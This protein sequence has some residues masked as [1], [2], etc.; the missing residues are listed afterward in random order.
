MHKVHR[1]AK[2]ALEEFGV[3]GITLVEMPDKTDVTT[4]GDVLEII[5]DLLMVIGILYN[6]VQNHGNLLSNSDH[7]ASKE[8]GTIL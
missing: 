2:A 1:N 4:E 5:S 6:R 3:E 8:D 7:L